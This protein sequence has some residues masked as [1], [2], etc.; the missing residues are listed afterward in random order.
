MKKNWLL[1]VVALALV[2]VIL[3]VLKSP[4][5]APDLK[6]GVTLPLSGTFAPFGEDIKNG[7]EMARDKIKRDEGL[8]FEFI[9]EN[10]ESDAKKALPAAQKLVNIDKVDLII[11]GPGSTANLVI[12]PFM[13]SK[14]V[15][16][17]AISSTSKLN[18]AGRYVIK[19]QRDIDAEAKR[20]A[21]Y[22]YSKNLRT[23]GILYDVTS[24][25][26][27]IGKDVFI[28]TFEKLGGAV[29][30]TE[31][32]DSKSSSADYRAQIT[33]IK[34]AAPEAVYI[35]ANA[36]VGGPIVKQIRKLG[37]SQ[38]IFGF[39]GLQTEEFLS[40]AGENAE[41]VVYTALRFSCNEAQ[42]MKDY[43]E[44]YA[45]RFNG[46]VALQYGA[47]A[48]DI[49]NILAAE[50]SKKG[51]LTADEIVGIF[52]GK[53]YEGVNGRLAFDPEGNIVANDFV[54]RTVRDGQYVT[55]ESD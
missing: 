26:M 13:E 52:E 30:V 46:R 3:I 20:M 41:G 51:S 50:L 55:I 4:S 53:S 32:Y 43:C 29:K 25:T 2:A 38:P 12:A 23:A 21:E 44:G 39:S 28:G 49:A 45:G 16:F 48:Y 8:N 37:L 36:G 18:T 9:Y 17:I 7:L 47:H 15:P 6:V 27:T 11:S 14:K 33:K 34:A 5:T 35:L 24:D 40:G 22:I 42:A 31:A 54:I 1:A 10:S 19:A